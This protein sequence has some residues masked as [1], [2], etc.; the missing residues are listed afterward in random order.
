MQALGN[1][2]QARQLQRLARQISQLHA[3]FPAFS[4]QE[5]DF[6]R[7]DG[8][9]PEYDHRAWLLQ[10]YAGVYVH[11]LG[12]KLPARTQQQPAWPAWQV[13]QAVRVAGKAASAAASRAAQLRSRAKQQLAPALR[14]VA[15]L[16]GRTEGA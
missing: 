12:G 15:A 7:G 10:L 3:V 5:Y 8:F 6:P 13:Q 11:L 14:A 16:R 9:A 1:H 2:K 4:T